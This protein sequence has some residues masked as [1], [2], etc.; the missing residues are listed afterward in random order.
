[1]TRI[2]AGT[3]GGRRLA[4]PRRGTRPTSDRVREALFSAVEAAMDLDGARVLDLYA[5]TGALGLEALSRGAAHALLV[6][7]DPGAVSVLR[8]NVST[9][10]LAGASVRQGKVATVL[11][12]PAPDP[13]DLVLADPPYALPEPSLSADLVALAAWTRPGTL[14]VVERASRSAGVEWPPAWERGRVR[15]YG[16]T[17]LHW[18][19]V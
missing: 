3:A 11:A 4:V 14:V 6:E 2:V 15:T 9:L 10:G 18:A 12:E 17:A 1:M 8:R 7:S 5:G 16:D 13:F 19:T